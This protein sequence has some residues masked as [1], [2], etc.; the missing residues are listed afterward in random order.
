MANTFD[1]D[2]RATARYPRRTSRR[3]KG[4]IGGAAA[5]ADLGLFWSEGAS[6]LISPIEIDDALV[7]YVDRLF[8]R[9]PTTVYTLQTYERD[10]AADTAA[11]DRIMADIFDSLRGEEGV[12]RAWG[13]T[14]GVYELLE[15]LNRAGMRADTSEIPP[16]ASSW[17]VEYLDSKVGF[18]DFVMDGGTLSDLVRLP[19]GVTCSSVDEVVECVI[20]ALVSCESKVVRAN[21]GCA[22]SGVIVMESGR[23]WN[24]REDMTAYLNAR[25]AKKAQLFA[26]GPYLVDDYVAPREGTGNTSYGATFVESFV[27]CDGSIRILGL[28][29]ELR[30]EDNH[31]VGAEM[32]LDSWPPNAAEVL[33]RPVKEIC[34]AA[35]RLGYRG[36]LGVD[37]LWDEQDRPVAIEINPRRC[38]EASVYEIA[39]VLCGQN[40]S[41]SALCWS[42]SRATSIFQLHRSRS[43]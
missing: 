16:P 11:D 39:Q 38:S 27:G 30:V 15:S 6:A 20:Q 8:K 18:R 12:I 34:R 23:T 9:R 7:R 24:G 1:F 5:Y 35:S 17:T 22:G 31:Y 2:S 21:F 29:C 14:P 42:D 28:G 26:E 10:L 19:D 36:H 4:G 40:W 41:S 33:E 37:F 25:M 32:G 43:R 3:R 13:V